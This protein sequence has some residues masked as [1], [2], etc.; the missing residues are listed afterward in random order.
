[1][2]MI[3]KIYYIDFKYIVSGMLFVFLN[4]V[5]NIKSMIGNISFIIY[6]RVF[7]FFYF[8][9]LII[10]LFYIWIFKFVNDFK[11]FCV[12]VYFF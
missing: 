4:C 7:Y 8:R 11:Y 12:L 5:G 1:M 10:I 3:V 2:C 9:I 6:L